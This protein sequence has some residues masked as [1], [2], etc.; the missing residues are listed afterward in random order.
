VTIRELAQTYARALGVAPPFVHVPEGPVRFA[1]RFLEPLASRAGVTLPL[2][3]SGVDFF[4]FDRHF[5]VERARD[6]LGFHSSIGLAE[7]AERAVR[8]YEDEGLL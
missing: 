3:S 2:S 4:T 1:L 5:S 6:E 7:G 8:W